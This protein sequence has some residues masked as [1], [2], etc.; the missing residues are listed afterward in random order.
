MSSA[1]PGEGD[2]AL[3]L[4]RHLL[5]LL[6][7]ARDPQ[8]RIRQAAATAGVTERTV[9]AVVGELEAAGYL[10]RTRVGRHNSYQIARD[11]LLTIPGGA[12]VPL[13]AVLDVLLGTPAPAGGVTPDRF[14]RR[15]G[16]SS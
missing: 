4:S 13:G 9:Q 14:G 5:I 7:I 3:L 16:R 1:N 12:G 11:R 2:P 10:R 6:Q 15:V 8:I